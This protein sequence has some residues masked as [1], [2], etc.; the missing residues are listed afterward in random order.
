MP[1]KIFEAS[2]MRKPIV[3]GVEGFAAELVE[4]AGAGLCMQPENE[5]DL[6]AAVDRLAADPALCRRLGDAGY[7]RIAQRHSYDRLAAEYAQRLED[8]VA[9][10]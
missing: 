3:L 10:A 9:S 6:L 4:G 1:S 8:L 5:A 2:A 7:E